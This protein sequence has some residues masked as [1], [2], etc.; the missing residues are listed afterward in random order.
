L[1]A[2]VHATSAEGTTYRL[3][4]HFESQFDECIA[5]F[6]VGRMNW[7]LWNLIWRFQPSFFQVP[8]GMGGADLGSGIQ[9]FLFAMFPEVELD[10]WVTIGSAK[11]FRW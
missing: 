9:E 5:M 2:S 1:N 10:S 11:Q 4:A 6:A 8:L 3:Y 7:R